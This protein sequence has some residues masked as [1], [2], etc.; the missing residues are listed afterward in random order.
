MPT[1]TQLNAQLLYANLLEEI[2]L[3]IAT[4]D[5]CTLGFSGL[6]VPF[7]KD[8]CYLQIRMIC[9][10]VALGCLVAHGDIKQTSSENM[11]RAWSADK[12]MSPRCPDTWP[13]E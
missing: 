13:D 7:V 12:I 8:F 2:K 4:I 6:A 10:L 11:Q 9:E 5:H 1:K 3:R